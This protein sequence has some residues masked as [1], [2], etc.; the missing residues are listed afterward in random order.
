M[1]T[2]V[3][4]SCRRLADAEIVALGAGRPMGARRTTPAAPQTRRARHRHITIGERCGSARMEATVLNLLDR[5]GRCSRHAPTNRLIG[6]MR[7]FGESRVVT[8]R[9]AERPGAYT[10]VRRGG[11]VLVVRWCCPHPPLRAPLRFRSTQCRPNSAISRRRIA[12][13]AASL[14]SRG[15][16]MLTSIS[17]GRAPRSLAR[18]STRS[19]R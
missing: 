3:H 16:G 15:R 9:Y 14:R 18:T 4:R 13:N 1:M 10:V 11:E 5:L 17:R 2:H 12:T 6:L 7:R 8:R 19:P